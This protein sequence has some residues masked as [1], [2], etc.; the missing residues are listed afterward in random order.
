LLRAAAVEHLLDRRLREFRTT[1]ASVEPSAVDVDKLVDLVWSMF[2]G[3]AFVAWVELWVAART[4]TELAATM[5]E[6]DRRFTAESR[7]LAVAVLAGISVGAPGQFELARDFAFALMTGLA[8]QHLVARGQRPASEIIDALKVTV[9][10][11]LRGAGAE[12]V[13]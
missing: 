12:D 9:T 11:M 5:V 4:D 2:D 1:L 8:V 3:P 7:Q 6:V 10:S 13:S